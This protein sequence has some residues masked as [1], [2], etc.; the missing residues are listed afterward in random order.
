MNFKFQL[1]MRTFKTLLA[2]A[3][4]ILSLALLGVDSPFFACIA[5]IFVIQGD[6]DGSIN[7]AKN[8]VW[9][10]A[11]GAIISNIVL[12]ALSFLPYN[13]YV[14]TIVTCLSIFLLIQVATHFKKPMAIFPGCIVLCA[15]LCTTTNIQTP[16]IYGIKRTIHTLYGALIGLAVNLYVCPYDKS[17]DHSEANDSIAEMDLV[18]DAPV[19]V[20]ELGSL[21][22]TS[23][24][25]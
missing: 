3:L 1:G 17:K 9:G 6:K 8:R 14:Q 25:L 12:F 13:A 21:E 18:G 5:T 24:N 15:I 16:I 11:Y 19:M 7:N 4:C 10:T 23:L 22:D 20:S 2:V